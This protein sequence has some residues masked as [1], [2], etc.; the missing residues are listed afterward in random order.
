[1]DLTKLYDN[2]LDSDFK[3]VLK[4]GAFINAHKIVLRSQSKWFEI[5]FETA[6]GPTMTFNDYSD[7]AV[8]FVIRYLYNFEGYDP[9]IWLELFLLADMMMNDKM[10]KYLTCNMDE[11]VPKNVDFDQI[12]AVTC[13]LKHD[14][15]LRLCRICIYHKTYNFKTIPF[16]DYLMLRNYKTDSFAKKK[17]NVD[18]DYL[19]HYKRSDLLPQILLETDFT[20]FYKDDIERVINRIKDCELD[21]LVVHLLKHIGRGH[22]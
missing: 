6:D 8:T 19:I 16:V 9:K 4:T 2:P 18:I 22:Y 10:I 13:S 1:M 21:P 15:L 7:E 17:L 5:M 3:I 20:Y 14:R 12:I 11:K